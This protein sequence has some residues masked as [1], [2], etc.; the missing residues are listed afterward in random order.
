MANCNIVTVGLVI[1]VVLIMAFAHNLFTT[2][3]ILTKLFTDTTN[4]ALLNLLVILILLLDLASGIILAFLVL[5]LALYIKHLSQITKDRFSDI[6]AM[7]SQLPVSKIPLSY[8]PRSYTSESEINYKTPE[9]TNGNIPPFQPVSQNDITQM[10]PQFIPSALCN[11]NDS[12]TQVGAPDRDGY[13]YTGCRY[14]MKNSP[15]NLTKWGPPLAH[16]GTYDTSKIAKC[17]TLFYPL[18]A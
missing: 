3:P 12:I 16:C 1:G 10:T 15:Q 17:G 5:Y 6:L 7:T 9:I 11:Q 13:D 14:D 8:I 2:F 18:N 4:F